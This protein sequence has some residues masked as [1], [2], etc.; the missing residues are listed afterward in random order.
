MRV[1]TRSSHEMSSA[2]AFPAPLKRAPPGKSISRAKLYS[3]LMANESVLKATFFLF[4]FFAIMWALLRHSQRPL[5]TFLGGHLARLKWGL[6]EFGFKD[7]PLVGFKGDSDSYGLGIRL[8][9]YLQWLT[10]LIITNCLEEERQ[11]ISMAYLIFSISIPVALFLKLFGAAFSSDCIFA[12]EVFIA[13]VFLWGGYYITQIP[14]MQAISLHKIDEFRKETRVRFKMPPRSSRTVIWSVQLLAFVVSPIT[15]WFWCQISEGV[16]RWDFVGT[17]GGTKYFFFWTRIQ[18]HTVKNFATWMTI[19]S[20]FNIPWLFYA[21]I[22]TRLVLLDD[23]T[24]TTGDGWSTYVVTIGSFTSAFIFWPHLLGLQTLDDFLRVVFTPAIEYLTSLLQ[25]I[26]GPDSLN[27]QTGIPHSQAPPALQES[28]KAENSALNESEGKEEEEA[29][30]AEEVI[31][32]ELTK[33]VY[34]PSTLHIKSSNHSTITANNCPHPLNK[35]FRY[36]TAIPFLIAAYCILAV[37]MT[38]VWNSISD[39]YDIRSVGQIIPL[40]ISTGGLLNVL[41]KVF[42]QGK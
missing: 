26:R 6:P 36:K 41:L 19:A 8:G 25:Q 7:N 23:K 17:P 42:V 2:K 22:P 1:P 29:E 11:Y 35:S 10:D 20:M 14:M 16:E 32:P 39:V 15:L 9:V 21:I 18:G 13:L 27:H 34:L 37:E 40:V 28:E 30:E 3:L 31:L 38:L 12:V 33:Q 4:T 5:N 24:T